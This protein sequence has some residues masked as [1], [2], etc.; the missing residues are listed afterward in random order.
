M[1]KWFACLAAFVAV[2]A[3]AAVPA[4]ERDALIALYNDTGGTSWTEKSGWLGAAG[5]ECAWYAVQCDENQTTVIALDLYANNLTG[6]I[7]AAIRDL[8]GL[9]RFYFFD[10]NIGGTVPT[11][12]GELANLEELYLDRN[13]I[14]GNIPTSIGA[15]TKLRVLAINGT[16]VNGP[17]PAQLGNLTALE[18]LLLTYNSL[19]GEIPPQLG[20]LVNL[21]QLDFTSNQLTGPIP[22]EFRGLTKLEQMYVSLNNLSGTIPPELG[23]MTNLFQLKLAY[24]QLRG[25]IPTELRALRNLFNLD[26]SYNPIGGTIPK[27][28]AELTN[29]EILTL[30]S[31]Q[32]EGTIPP[33]LW[34]MTKLT[35]LNLDGNKLTGTLPPAIG[36]LVNLQTLTIST[37][38]LTGPIPKEIGK[39]TKLWTLA[40]AINQLDGQIPSEIGDLPELAYFE[41]A[42]NKLTGPIPASVGK[43]K[44]L[45][46][47]SVYENQLSGPIPP[48]LGTLPDLD[49]L[50]LAANQFTGTIP[51]S[52]RNLKKLRTLNMPGNLLTGSI[53]TWIG[54]LTALEEMFLGFNRFTGSIPPGIG[55]LANLAYLDVSENLLTGPLPAE[56]GNL[57]KLE[58]MTLSYNRFSGPIP[59]GLWQ[60][61]SLA[62]L[63]MTN[64]GVSGTLPPEI[65]NLVNLEG[66]GLGGNNLEGVVPPQVGNLSKLMYLSLTGNRFSG[67]LPREIGNLKNLLQVDFSYNAFTGPIPPEIMGMTGL[68]DRGS[69]FYYNKLFTNDP[70]VFQFVN[71]KQY[72][73][74][75]EVTQTITPTNVRITST[76]DRSAI[77]E[78]NPILYIYDEGGYQV[79]ASTTPGGGPVSIATTSAKE[80]NSI[81]V[82]NVQPST[83][84]FFTVSSVTHPHYG[85]QNLLISDP[86]AAVSAAT[87]PRVL[88]PADID[89]TETTRGLVQIDGVPRNEDRFTV[90]NFGDTASSITLTKEADFFTMEPIAFSL[91]GG[92]SQTVTIKSVPMPPGTYYGYV[93]VFGDGTG[94]GL[95]VGE[96]LLSV[97]KP[98]GTVR[99]EAVDSRV[100]IAG[101]PGSDSVGQAR[102]RNV[103]NAQLSGI[104][105]S[106][107]PWIIPNPDPI[108]IDPGQIGVVNFRIVRSRRPPGVEGAL[109]ANLS[110]VYVDGSSAG[111]LSPNISQQTPTGGVSVAKVT[112]VD[113]SKPALSASTI[114]PFLGGEVAYFLP[115]VTSF[116]R[117]STPY[118][119]D[120]SLLNNSGGR[121]INDL[122]IYY[123]PMGTQ[124]TS[125]ATMTSIP[126]TQS[127]TLAN[128][129]TNVYGA[130]TQVGSMQLRSS[131]WQN[132]VV[133]AKLLGLTSSGT[134]TGDVPVFRSDRGATSG[135]ITY[136]AGVRKSATTHSD[137]YV[138]EVGG[139]SAS[140]RVEFLDANGAAVG[141]VRTETLAPYGMLELLDA[142]PAA[143]TTAIITNLAGASGRLTAYAR[144]FDDSTGDSWSIV[145]WSRFQR[146]TLGE[147]VRVPFVDGA[148]AAPPGGKR[149]AVPHA[150][151][152][153]SSTELTLFNPSN[154]DVR[155]TVQVYDS[156]GS[157]SDREVVVGARRTMTLQDVGAVSRSADAYAV[158]TPFRGQLVVTA[159]SSRTSVPIVAASNGL[160]VGQ[161]QI[162]SSLEDSTGATVAAATPGTYRTSLGLVET[163]GFSA[164]VRAR[165]FL[166]EGRSLVSTALYRDYQLAPGQQIVA[167]QLVRAIVGAS[168]DTSLGDLHNLQLRIEV[169]D[170]RGSVVPF[171]VITDNA[172]SD[173]LL[174]LE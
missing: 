167:D 81:I 74:T 56:M 120:L 161:S 72:D 16:N 46:Y 100:E 77:V 39:L 131:E 11:Q 41:A 91:A 118:V 94:E 97:A 170:G 27:E 60:I 32:L 25:P 2:T 42:S 92:A 10:N 28:L 148:Q 68:I 129:V 108:T 110:L 156:S 71:R 30:N 73:G 37:N 119:S 8:K 21:Q 96:V 23:A 79:V 128:V 101:V 89:V 127:V 4:S 145:D 122:R 162:F 168:R 152:P 67:P 117:G 160:R 36:N 76:T 83:T 31:D 111:A 88:A 126:S 159:H 135:Q 87:G 114:P 59:S 70:A 165:V 169:I 78:W 151:A 38:Q 33:E 35:Y 47:F 5:T 43:L 163:S 143:A 58:Y 53:P 44:K 85:Q 57:K 3:S 166:D 149:R 172:T 15:L 174:R 116:L 66:L 154:A 115:G 99:A 40:L 102:F 19:S 104:V 164:V 29:L 75:F 1:H 173:S 124:Q 113:V 136:L 112:V 22:R 130:A 146:F 24:N 6:T 50:Y 137:I 123:T 55:A 17:I 157:A 82:R 171:V 51:E 98:T 144:V 90:T 54:E 18:E 132:L 150:V 139:A 63:Q 95:V 107:Q 86:T 7:P 140:A 84:Y 34:S 14:G 48:E 64:I 61:P 121:S 65:G 45:F 109:S 134:F 52:F 141:Q 20:Q 153:R 13:P 133:Q 125:V 103:G 49:T 62:S 12:L 80:I 138:Q 9:R 142:V 155:A 93:A 147:A 69:D 105:L 106:D 158:V 26:L